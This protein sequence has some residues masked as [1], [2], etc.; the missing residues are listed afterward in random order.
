MKKLLPHAI[1]LLLCL[2]AFCACGKCEVCTFG[3]WT[4]V[5]PATCT[6]PGTETRVCAEC[7]FVEERE[8]PQ[9]AHDMVFAETK[10]A[11]TCTEKGKEVQ[12]CSLCHAQQEKDLPAKGHKYGA[13]EIVTAATCTKDGESKRNCL[14]CE[15]VETRV[16]HA[17]HIWES[18]SCTQAEHCTRCGRTGAKAMGHS[19]YNGECTRCGAGLIKLPDT[20]KL[21]HYRSDGKIE[22]STDVTGISVKYE[23]SY[24][25]TIYA[26]ITYTGQFTYNKD[27]ANR[28]E[29]LHIGY[30][31]YDS[32]N[33]VVE[34]GTVYTDAVK[35]GE[36]YRKTSRIYELNPSESYTLVLLDVGD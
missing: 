4:T 27:G 6:Q 30:K 23:K 17:A 18:A 34:S 13:W 25:G 11:P 14:N 7:E 26:D 28:S 31:L 9:L 21:I 8:I 15:K 3:D 5:T 10:T 16:D 24:D 22:E 33:V 12:A 35:V 20:P 36:K 2:L 1:L 19:Y 29:R 32:D